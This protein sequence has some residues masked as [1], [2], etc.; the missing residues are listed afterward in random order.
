PFTCN[1]ARTKIRAW[2]LRTECRWI[3]ATIPDDEERRIA[4]L[5]ELKILDT[6]PEE[7]FDRITRL[8]AALFNVPMAVIIFIDEDRQWFK[9]CLGLNAKETPRDAAFCAHVVYSRE[10]MIVPDAF[11]DVRFADN[12]VVTNEPRMTEA[13]LALY[14]CLIHALGLL[15]ALI[16]S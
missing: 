7:R 12:P 2:V 1:Y 14:V 16:L 4:S 3:R 11:Q 10:L 5:R 15:K 6:E 8:A 9:S 13:A